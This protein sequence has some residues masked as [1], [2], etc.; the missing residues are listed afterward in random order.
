LLSDRDGK[1]YKLRS[2]K[3]LSED[4]LRLAQKVHI[5]ADDP[6][7]KLKFP[8]PIWPPAVG[9]GSSLIQF[10]EVNFR[11][12]PEKPPLLRDLTFDVTRGSKIALVGRNGAGKSTLIR[13]MT[14]ELN[15]FGETTAY[16]RW[17]LPGLRIGHVTQYAVEELEDYADQTVVDYAEK[18]L[19]SGKSSSK[20]IADASGNIRQFLG[21][22]G[23][24]G[25]HAFRQ[26]GKLSGGERMRLC[27]ATVLADEP[28][29]LI[30]DESTNHVDLETLDTMSA[31]LNVFQGA[32][33]MVSHNQAFL[34]GFCK[35]LWA[36]EDGRL[37]V[38][39]DDTKSFDEMFSEYRSH[40]LSSGAASGRTNQRRNKADMAKRASKQNTGS[41]MNT[42]LL[43]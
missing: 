43:T 15:G 18:K 28:Q 13:L 21:A 6:V 42:T 16:N 27:F 41:K 11:Y 3:K 36:L 12:G 33:I 35:E 22:F 26:I 24:G 30:L 32:V 2:I 37:T 14:D 20:I 10:E 34:S 1:R 5:E 7:I 17:S 4:S 23:L 40:I 39:H 9:E 25:K 19:A 8:D 31:A 29:V 38:S